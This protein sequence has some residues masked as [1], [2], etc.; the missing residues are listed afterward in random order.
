M[1][2][3]RR[4]TRSSGGSQE[5]AGIRQPIPVERRAL[6]NHLCRALGRATKLHDALGDPVGIPLH[7]PGHFVEEFAQGEERDSFD[8]PAGLPT[9][10]LQI[11]GVG[12]AG[13]Q[14]LNHLGLQVFGQ[15]MRV[16]GHGSNPFTHTVFCAILERGDAVFDVKLSDL[17]L[18]LV[19]LVEGVRVLFSGPPLIFIIPTE[20]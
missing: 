10:Q 19:F 14:D 11:D 4:R 20:R 3:A 15:G 2:F 9:L 8:V 7:F 13:V 16:S 5:L 12:E 18:F 6:S 17:R 1:A